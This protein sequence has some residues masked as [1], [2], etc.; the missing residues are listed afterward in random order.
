MQSDLARRPRGLALVLHSLSPTLIGLLCYLLLAVLLIGAHLLALSTSGTAYPA[1]FDDNL[2]QGYANFVIQPVA[3]VVNNQLLNN[4]VTILLWGAVG[5]AVC[6]VMATIAGIINDWRNTEES[7]TVPREG[8]VIR[9][10]LQRSLITRLL[11]RTFVGILVILFTALIL[12]A[13]RFCLENDLRAMASSS[14]SEGFL[15]SALG[16]LVW[17]AIF[18]GYVILFRL[19]VLRTR[20]F[21]EIL[22]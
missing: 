16:A 15:I 6:A 22:Y 18:H 20:V 2:L 1:S 8:V 13:V 4:V 11:W 3:T 17:I 19:Y 9:H 21:G 7:I 10:P 14:Y 12:P 5:A